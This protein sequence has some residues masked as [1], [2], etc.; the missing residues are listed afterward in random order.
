MQLIQVACTVTDTQHDASVR[1]D[2]N[3][4]TGKPALGSVVWHP[5]P[6]L[7]QAEVRAAQLNSNPLLKTIDSTEIGVGVTGCESTTGVLAT[8]AG[9]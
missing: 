4:Y 9:H 3:T 5:G 6:A 7:G 1:D 2:V 8:A